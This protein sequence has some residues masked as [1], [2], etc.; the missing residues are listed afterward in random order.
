MA[1]VRVKSGKHITPD[2]ILHVVGDEFDA[3]EQELE[4]FGD[5]FILLDVKAAETQSKK[6]RTKDG[7]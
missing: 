4:A 3:T 7:E 1:M 6:A 5:K 2:G